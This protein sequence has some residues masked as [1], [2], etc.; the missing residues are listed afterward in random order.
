MYNSRG[1]NG[2]IQ[3]R[4]PCRDLLDHRMAVIVKI[5]LVPGHY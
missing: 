5:L 3:T 4:D 1:D 2:E